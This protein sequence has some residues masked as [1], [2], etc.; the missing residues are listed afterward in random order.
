V[1]SI[2][3]LKASYQQGCQFSD[4]KKVF[5]LI[6]VVIQI[7]IIIIGQIEKAIFLLKPSLSHH[8]R[9]PICGNVD[10]VPVHV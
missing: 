4:F 8:I 9:E 10:V 2:V 3:P 7:I 1:E 5:F 6:R